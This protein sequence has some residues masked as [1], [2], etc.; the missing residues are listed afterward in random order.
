MTKHRK[1][2]I[3]SEWDGSGWDHPTISWPEMLNM[4]QNAADPERLRREVE[5]GCAGRPIARSMIGISDIF[6]TG[7][8]QFW[9]L[10]KEAENKE[11][12]EH[13]IM[14]CIIFSVASIDAR[15]SEW[16]AV[17]REIEHPERPPRFWEK[18]DEAGS[19]RDRWDMVVEK[20]GGTQWDGSK[21]PFQSHDSI[22]ALR[23]ELC[24]FTPKMLSRNEAPKKRIKAIIEHIGEWPNADWIG[25]EMDFWTQAI[26]NKARTAAWC[27]KETDKFHKDFD[28]LLWSR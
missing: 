12:I 24:H 21:N 18:V 10:A 9:S 16:I 1:S 20:F 11:S 6:R 23:N 3:G 2:G 25:D 15:L 22:R 19:T 7:Y 5:E 28:T 17:F 8:A 4:M 14:A 26:L 27:C 13:Y